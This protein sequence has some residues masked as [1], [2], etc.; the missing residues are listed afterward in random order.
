[1][2]QSSKEVLVAV[3]RIVRRLRPAHRG[4]ELT[5]AGVSLLSHLEE[6]GPSGPAALAELER[7][8]PPVVCT[9]LSGL[10]RLG[11]V[12]RD[13]DPDDGRR[14][15]MSLTED[16]RSEVT[17]HWS[18]ASQRVATTLA[19]RF[20]AKERAQLVAAVPLLQRLA[21]EL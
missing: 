13:S 10:Q 6:L 9:T 20:T 11:L 3:G 18:T 16:G 7:V 19:E 14:V 21:G 12:R 17:A 2:V 5:P 8:T 15:L 4:G 1:M